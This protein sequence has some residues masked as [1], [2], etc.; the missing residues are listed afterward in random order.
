MGKKKK[1]TISTSYYDMPKMTLH[2][3]QTKLAFTE[4]PPT[5][6]LHKTLIL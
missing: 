3:L 1:K 2:V 4:T 5:I 6:V